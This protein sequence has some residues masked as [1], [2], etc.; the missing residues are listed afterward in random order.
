M[1]LLVASMEELVLAMRMMRPEVVSAASWKMAARI[2]VAMKVSAEEN[3]AKMDQ[4][5]IMSLNR[6]Q[7]S[8]LL[9]GVARQLSLIVAPQRR[10]ELIIMAK[11]QLSHLSQLSSMTKLLIITWPHRHQCPIYPP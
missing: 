2:W 8:A 3:S 7:S 6:I 11:V 4:A 9:L 1:V 10:P 5:T